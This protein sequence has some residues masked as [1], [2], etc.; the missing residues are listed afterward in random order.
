MI[1]FRALSSISDLVEIVPENRSRVKPWN[2]RGSEKKYF[3]LQ[4][5]QFEKI[6]LFKKLVLNVV[7]FIKSRNIFLLNNCDC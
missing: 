5:L 4:S 2:N 3:L 7:K 6:I 1:I